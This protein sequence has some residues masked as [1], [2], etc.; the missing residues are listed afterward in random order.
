ML[1]SCIEPV[2]YKQLKNPGPKLVVNSYITP[3]SLMDFY[4]NKTADIIDT[5]YNIT[6]G[7][8]EIWEDDILLE[9]IKEH[10]QGHFVS[11]YKPKINSLYKIV[12]EADGMQV[13]AQTTIPDSTH[14]TNLNYVYPAGESFDT[15]FNGKYAQLFIE[16]DD[17]ITENFY[18]LTAWGYMPAENKYNLGQIRSYNYIIQAEGDIYTTQKLLFSDY[19][20]NGQKVV[21]DAESLNTTE[22]RPIYIEGSF[23][24]VI[25]LRTLS[26]EYYQYQ[27]NLLKHF[28]NQ[29]LIQL[30]TTESIAKMQL[31]GTPIDVYSNIKGGYGIFAGYSSFTYM[32]DNHVGRY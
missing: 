19:L 5:N 13:S 24:T 1:Y 18:E 9:T 10:K 29:G 25:V 28:Y 8:I 6:Q 17:P 14:I 15:Y 3:D 31:T 2:N 4:V 32:K 27:K 12:V 20:F 16:I 21:L 26:K 11:Q 22:A 23:F 7:S 30:N